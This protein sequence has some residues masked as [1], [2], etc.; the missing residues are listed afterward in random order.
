MIAVHC[1]GQRVHE[2]PGRIKL[3][4]GDVLLLEGGPSFIGKTAENDR[5][6]ALLAEVKNSAPPRLEALIPALII[7]ITI[8]AIFTAGVNSLSVSALVASI[9]F[10]VIEQ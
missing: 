8:L 2:H 10:L 4:A 3:Q 7:A 5:A 6:F 1:E 9:A